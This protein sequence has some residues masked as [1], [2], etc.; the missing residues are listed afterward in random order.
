MWW[1]TRA[2]GVLLAI[3]RKLGVLAACGTAGWGQTAAI[4]WVYLL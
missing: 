4:T 1:G 2:F 3:S